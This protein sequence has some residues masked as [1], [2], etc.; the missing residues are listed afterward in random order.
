MCQN[1]CWWDSSRYVRKAAGG[2]LFNDAVDFWDYMAS[3]MTERVWSIGGIILTGH[4]RST[5]WKTCPSDTFSTT[6]STRSSLG[7]K[8]GVCGVRPVTNRLSL[9][10][11]DYMQRG[12]IFKITFWHSCDLP[13]LKVG[14]TVARKKKEIL[15]F[16]SIN[17]LKPTGY[18]MHQQV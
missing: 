10:Y 1:S 15:L 6:P 16:E 14:K 18:V 5:R 12:D 7:I 9:G 4:N 3:M 17:L 8:T 11:N 2:M 13:I